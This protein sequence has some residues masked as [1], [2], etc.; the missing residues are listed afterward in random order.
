M[1]RLLS[2]RLYLRFASAAALLALAFS[3]GTLD[4]FRLSAAPLL[5]A[6][7]GSGDFTGNV[8]R[9]NKG[10]RL[11]LFNS[12]AGNS[13]AND[14][15]RSRVPRRFESGVKKPVGCD[16]AFSPVA[17]PSAITVYGRCIV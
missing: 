2:V 6:P 14:T 5:K 11:P 10:D 15:S 7:A 17:S 9:S 8:N 16:P 3:I 12:G 13:E 1:A 4:P